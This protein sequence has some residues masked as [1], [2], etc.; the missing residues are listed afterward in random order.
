MNGLV[1]KWCHFIIINDKYI[2]NFKKNFVQRKLRNWLT[3]HGE[4]KSKSHIITQACYF[5]SFFFILF[6]VTYFHNMSLCIE[7]VKLYTYKLHLQHF[8][9]VNNNKIY[10]SKNC[11]KLHTSENNFCDFKNE[12]R[13]YG[14]HN[15]IMRLI[16]MPNISYS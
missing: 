16:K 7:M 12:M 2:V 14:T 4:M 11:Y 10:N 5:I 3:I 15:T 6:Y 13:I 1:I 8:S 9:I